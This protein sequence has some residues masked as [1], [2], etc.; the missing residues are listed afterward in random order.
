MAAGGGRAFATFLFIA[1]LVAIVNV[2]ILYCGVGALG[3]RRPH[4]VCLHPASALLVAI[5]LIESD[6]ASAILTLERRLNKLQLRSPCVTQ[7]P[8]PLIDALRP[9]LSVVSRV[10]TGS[11]IDR[12]HSS[13]SKQ[14]SSSAARCFSSIEAHSITSLH[15]QYGDFVDLNDTTNDLFLGSFALAHHRRST[16][17]W[18]SPDVMTLQDRWLEMLQCEVATLSGAWMIGSPLLMDCEASWQPRPACCAAGAAQLSQFHLSATGL[19][20]AAE[21]GFSV[22]IREWRESTVRTQ[23]F[24]VALSM[25]VWQSYYEARQ[26]NL[27][28]RFVATEV[29]CQRRDVDARIHIFLYSRLLIE[30][31]THLL[32]SQTVVCA[33]SC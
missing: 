15:E 20:A 11:G 3:P 12:L 19:Y 4:K 2:V 7:T 32:Y 13:L 30:L 24:H 1:L 17:L 16:L 31:V 21:P 29:I 33:A 5:P 26:R 8:Q 14:L 10:K 22:Y 9:R 28:W 25:Y 18:L 6:A 23:P 27:R